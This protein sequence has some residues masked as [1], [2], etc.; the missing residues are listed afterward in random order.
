MEDG[1]HLHRELLFAAPA[2][3]PLLIGEPNQIA[4]LTTPNAEL[5]TIRPTHLSHFIDANLLIAKVLY[6]VYE[7]GWVC[8][9]LTI[10]N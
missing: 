7:C 5:L 9:E 1:S 10:A 4:S 8:H 6:C 2:L 3:P